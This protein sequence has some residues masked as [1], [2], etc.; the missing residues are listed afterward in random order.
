MPKLE[1]RP[2]TLLSE[3]SVTI[4]WPHQYYCKGFFPSYS[5]FYYEKFTLHVTLLANRASKDVR[6]RKPRYCLNSSTIKEVV[7]FTCD[8]LQK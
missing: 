4:S 6:P 2:S 1:I 3:V 7:I 8:I 5:T